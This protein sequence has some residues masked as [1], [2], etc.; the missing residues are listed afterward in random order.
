MEYSPMCVCTPRPRST[1]TASK[2]VVP[3]LWYKIKGVPPLQSNRKHT[4]PIFHERTYIRV[5]GLG[6]LGSIVRE[7]RSR[8][9]QGPI[10][11]SNLVATATLSGPPLI[12]ARS[13]SPSLASAPYP[14]VFFFPHIAFGHSAKSTFCLGLSF[15]R[16]ARGQRK[17]RY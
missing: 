13:I 10:T 15:A 6:Q 2:S 5:P 11:L 3:R 4:K 8:V 7:K 17:N 9:P 16:W 14:H 1:I 12:T